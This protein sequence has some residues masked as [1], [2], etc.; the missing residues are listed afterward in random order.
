[1]INYKSL[2]Y[3][4][5]MY[6]IQLHRFIIH[7]YFVPEMETESC[8][9]IRKDIFLKKNEWDDDI[10]SNNVP[11]NDITTAHTTIMFIIV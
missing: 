10:I 4:Q 8:D 11:L 3:N 6:H 9:C 1:M 7:N 5:Q 2:G